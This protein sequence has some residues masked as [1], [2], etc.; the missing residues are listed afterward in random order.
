MSS[1]QSFRVCKVNLATLK[2]AMIKD[3]NARS[4]SG[5]IRKVRDARER[6]DTYYDQSYAT[7]IERRE[8]VRQELWNA[9]QEPDF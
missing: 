3:V 9:A 6:G 1:N 2:V 8:A 4:P 7:K 5:S